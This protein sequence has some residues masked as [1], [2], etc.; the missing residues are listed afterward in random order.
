MF[1]Q[2]LLV[3]GV[4]KI[5]QVFSGYS[6]TMLFSTSIFADK[7]DEM[8]SA[9]ATVYIGAANAFAVVIFSLIVDSI[10]SEVI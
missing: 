5:M 9:R 3:G 7:N 8:A 4:L 6:A 2:A 1:R 10:F